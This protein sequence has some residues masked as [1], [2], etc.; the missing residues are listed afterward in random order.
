MQFNDTLQSLRGAV[1]RVRPAIDPT[2]ADTFI[3]YRMRQ[4]I[5]ARPFWSGMIGKGILN[6][7][8]STTVGSVTI[9]QNSPRVT[10][11]GNS[12]FPV[13]DVI[14]T[15]LPDG[16]RNTGYQWVQPASMVGIDT[17]TLLYVD[18]AGTPEVVAVIETT[19]TSFRATFTQPH[20][21]GCTATTSSLAYQQF[22]V[23]F[24][25]PLYTVTAVIDAN[26]FLI[27]P[28]WAGTTLVG[29]SYEIL[30]VYSI[31]QPDLKD[32]ISVVD[33]QTGQTLQVH[34]PRAQ[35]D[36][37]DPQRSAR[38]WPQYVSDYST[39]N[40]NGNAW[41]EIYPWN[42]SQRQLYY[43]YIKQIQDMKSPT[44]RPMP[45][46]DPSIYVLGAIADAFRVMMQGDNPNF[47]LA[48]AEQWERKFQMSLINAMA[49][50]DGKCQ[51][52]YTWSKS[53]NGAPGGANFWQSHDF[54]VWS[55]DF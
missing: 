42:T 33:P 45:F 40:L 52:A 7:P 28:A 6:L 50:D 5:D 16:I 47:N 36:W 49:A 3:N 18:A 55:G 26:T 4:V 30:Q 23:G 24:Q 43:T 41:Y 46:I 27:D 44:D 48:A 19:V 22:S 34:Y 10:I 1:A 25:Y 9:T 51:A 13:S 12:P 17:N 38:D 31:F 15:T 39:P 8:N 53:A 11:T 29:T 14:N 54:G 32:F 2:L 35:L 37:D 20:N 21:S